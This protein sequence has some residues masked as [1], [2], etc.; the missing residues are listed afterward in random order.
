MIQFDS[1]LIFFRWVETIGLVYLPFQNLSSCPPGGQTMQFTTP[2]P[3]SV[4]DWFGRELSQRYHPPGS[5]TFSPPENWPSLK[6]F[7]RKP[8]RLPVPS[9][10][11][12]K[13]AAKL[14]RCVWH[15]QPLGPKIGSLRHDPISWGSGRILKRS[16][17]VSERF[18]WFH[19]FFVCCDF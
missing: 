5:L 9:F 4:W 12:G 15:F 17:A 3:L 19:V 14:R 18:N 1:W 8:D 7:K 16:V 13:L 2:A 10:F 11:R 6:I